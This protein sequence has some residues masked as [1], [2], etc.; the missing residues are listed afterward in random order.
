LTYHQVLAFLQPGIILL[1][2][3]LLWDLVEDVYGLCE[4]VSGVEILLCAERAKFEGV[5]L[6]ETWTAEVRDKLSM[7][8]ILAA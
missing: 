4:I 5:D 7:S 3:E 2:L 6:D 8:S 1:E